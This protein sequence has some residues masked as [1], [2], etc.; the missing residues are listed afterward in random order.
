VYPVGSPHLPPPPLLDPAWYPDPTGRYEARYW[1]GRK[2]TSH[3]SHY[4]ATGNDPLLRA[5]W[6]RWYLRWIWRVA[7]WAAIVGAGFWAYNEYWPTSDRDVEAEEQ[8]LNDSAVLAT[9]LPATQPWAPAS[10]GAVSVLT[11][12][13]TEDAEG[14]SVV[15]EPLCALA[16]GRVEDA[17]DEP[18]VLR[19]F[20]TADNLSWI[21]QTNTIGGGAG[22]A[23]AYL[24][25]LREVEAGPCLTA[26]WMTKAG[27]G[28]FQV[29]ATQAMSEPSFGDEAVWWRITGVDTSGAFPLEVVVDLVYVRVDRI[30][31]EYS[32]SGSV[33]A[34]GV[35]VQRDVISAGVQ[36]AD[37]ALTEYDASEDTD[38]EDETDPGDDPAQPDAG[39]ESGEDG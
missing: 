10:G 26:L 24:D 17:A 1:D 35:D 23:K 7:I 19:A 32:F 33:E 4:G 38:T 34:I 16:T 27:A 14:E 18:Q 13:V 15:A 39:P 3:I 29:S 22:L 28:T 20:E 25:D 9:D 37:V 11:V 6:D 31:G 8:L 36:R 2:W 21:A 30:I 12:E 5:R